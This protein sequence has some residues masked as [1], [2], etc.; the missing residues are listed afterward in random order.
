ML[1]FQGGCVPACTPTYTCWGCSWGFR[2][3]Q[4][5][6]ISSRTTQ[7]VLVSVE[8][9]SVVSHCDVGFEYMCTHTGQ[10]RGGRDV[11]WR[12]ELILV[13]GGW[14]GTLDSCNALKFAAETMTC[15]PRTT[16][17]HVDVVTTK[18]VIELLGISPVCL[19][20]CMYAATSTLI[21]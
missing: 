12:F 11:H 8:F 20:T 7:V 9:W 19:R 5:G 17:L 2:S 3:T 14:I 6:L 4:E 16:G 1:L 21:N 13:I 15:L 10:C 18:I